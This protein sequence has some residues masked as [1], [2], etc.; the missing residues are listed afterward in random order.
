MRVSGE[1][2]GQVIKS[3]NS[4]LHLIYQ[5]FFIQCPSTFYLSLES[6]SAV[7]PTF[8]E[9]ILKNIIVLPSFYIALCKNKYGYETECIIK[10]ITDQTR[11][12]V[13]KSIK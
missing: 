11:I 5:I 13:H 12:S 7:K 1:G 8:L 9:Y 3:K 10:T 2:N 4:S 6:S